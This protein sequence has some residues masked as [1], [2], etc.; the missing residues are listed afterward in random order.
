MV[1]I[2]C[3]LRRENHGVD[4]DDFAVVILE[5]D[6]AFCIRTQPWQGAIFTH[7]SLTLYQTVR[8]GDWRRHQYVG[9]ICRV[10]KHQ[11]LVARALFQRICA[12]NALVDIRRLFANCAQYRARVGVKAHVGMHI[13]NFAHRITGNLFDIDPGA[14]GDLTAN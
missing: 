4:T 10:A 11:A 9:F 14:G 6:L 1:D 13:A 12:V 5:S 7:F 2:F 3:V 8:V